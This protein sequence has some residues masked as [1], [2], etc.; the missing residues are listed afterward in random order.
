MLCWSSEECLSEFCVTNRSSLL[1]VRVGDAK[2]NGIWF[3]GRGRWSL[4]TVMTFSSVPWGEVVNV[5]CLF[6]VGVCVWPA[7]RRCSRIA[8]HC[9]NG[10][11]SD[12]QI[13][14]ICIQGIDL[15]LNGWDCICHRSSSCCGTHVDDYLIDDGQCWIHLLIGM[16]H[17]VIA[18]CLI[19]FWLQLWCLSLLQLWIL[20]NCDSMPKAS[21][22]LLLSSK[23]WYVRVKGCSCLM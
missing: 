23:V 10:Y 12:T 4:C 2:G 9:P 15:I 22:T 21:W 13:M 19:W 5:F 8:S 6:T 3:S 16:Y 17:L 7:C 20:G 14:C 11:C 18:F 1:F